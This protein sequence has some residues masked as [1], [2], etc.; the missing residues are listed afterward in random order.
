MLVII[1]SCGVAS[2]VC[3]SVDMM[4]LRGLLKAL[5]LLAPFAASA[6]S[7]AS[8]DS[9][10]TILLDNNLQGESRQHTRFT[11]RTKLTKIIQ[12]PAVPLQTP[13]SL[14]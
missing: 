2:H 7:P 4:A 11:A 3:V 1:V 13:R 5:A 12:E 9:D 8:L 10:L 14:F 6:P